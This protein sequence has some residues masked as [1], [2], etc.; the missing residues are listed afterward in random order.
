M[1]EVKE[2]DKDFSIAGSEQYY[3]VHF[4]SDGKKVSA[5]CACH[6][7]QFKTLCKHVMSCIE[8]DAEIKE[9]LI[10]SGQWQ[11]YEEYLQRLKDA[12]QVKREAKNIKKKFERILLEL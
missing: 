7:G 4:W 9:A 10:E 8:Q 12:E 1:R 2:F 11:V 3:D 5:H 6:A